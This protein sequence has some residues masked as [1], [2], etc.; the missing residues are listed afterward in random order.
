MHYYFSFNSRSPSGLRRV[1]AFCQAI[2]S[3]FNS[4][5]PSGLRHRPTANDWSGHCVS[6][7]A[8]QAGCDWGRDSTL[9]PPTSFNSRSPSGLRRDL[10]K[11]PHVSTKFQFTQP[12]RAAT[13]FANSKDSFSLSFQFTQPK[14]AATQGLCHCQRHDSRF[15]SRS[16]S[17][18]RRA[19]NFVLTQ[20]KPFQFTQPKRAATVYR[21]KSDYILYVS[22]HAAQVGCDLSRSDSSKYQYVS[23]HAAQ[24]GCDK[25]EWIV[26]QSYISFNSRSPSGLRQERTPKGW[27]A[28]QVSI[29]AAQAGCDNV[30]ARSSSCQRVFQFTQPKRAATCV[31]YFLGGS[32]RVSIHAAQAGC[33]PHPST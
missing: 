10:R 25:L 7:H 8:A 2:L 26:L 5:S 19:S 13:P 23:I 33:D 27:K 3:C 31:L 16:P 30:P 20:I 18:L 6:I 9:P 22:I 17:G 21:L 1:I 28:E 15:N 12:K 4:R 24:A 14:R 29:H 11:C 32:G